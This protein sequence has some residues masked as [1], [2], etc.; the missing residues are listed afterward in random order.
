MK[1]TSEWITVNSLKKKWAIASATIIFFTFTLF[2]VIQY[3]SLREWMLEEEKKGVTQ[4]LNDLFVFFQQRGP[5][6]T[7]QEILESRDL[8]QQILDRNQTVVIVNHLGQEVLSIESN[9]VSLAN[10]PIKLINEKN[11]ELFNY[12]SNRYY[13]AQGPIQSR[14]F[15]GHIIVVSPLTRFE[16]MMTNLFWLT[17]GLGVLALIISSIAGYQLAKR[18]SSPIKQLKD[19]I[20]KIEK[21]GLQERV[22]LTHSHDEI[23]E[24]LELFNRMMGKVERSFEQQQQ[25]VEDASHELRTPLQII[26]GHIRM[27]QRWGKSEPPVLEESLE[28]SL[29]EIARLKGLVEDL[30][31]L[32]NHETKK[33]EYFKTDTLALVKKVLEDFRRLYPEFTFSLQSG[34]DLLLAD[35][36]PQHLEQLLLILLDNSVKYSK[37]RK[38]LIVSIQTSGENVS[39]SIQDFGHGISKEDL[40]KIYRRFYRADKSRSRDS[41]GHGLGLSIARRI[42]EF[43]EGTLTLSSEIGQGTN[44]MVTIPLSRK[45]E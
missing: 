12:E 8:I 39:V 40:P 14:E 43:N 33:V 4:A 10:M 18:L 16:Q 21:N 41:G 23:G 25:F 22:D 32:T 19:T 31:I 6:I 7:R 38:E 36:S 2:S 34:K 17:V 15:N 11:T 27:L 28:T 44:A 3:V 1:R 5:I 30:L 45:T 29:E 13:L 9:S 37:E 35:I 24:L 26:E 42:I 20:S